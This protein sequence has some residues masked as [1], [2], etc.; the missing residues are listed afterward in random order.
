MDYHQQSL[1][2]TRELDDRSG[3]AS[4]LGNLGV[5]Y[6]LLGQYQK[7]INYHQQSLEIVRVISD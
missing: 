5:D 4:S 2:I 6:H 3:E 7:A 1:A